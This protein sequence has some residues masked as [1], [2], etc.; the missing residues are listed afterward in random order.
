MP[1]TRKA[2]A[3]LEALS[4]MLVGPMSM[5]MIVSAPAPMVSVPILLFLLCATVVAPLDLLVDIVFLVVGIL[6]LSI[7]SSFRSATRSRRIVKVRRIA[8]IVGVLDLCVLSG[9][10]GACTTA[11]LD[12]LI[13]SVIVFVSG[14]GVLGLIG[15]V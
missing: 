11:S 3:P 15:H 2:I 9:L 7:R 6:V 13:K 14:T 12:L 1:A 4:M 10:S 5:M 8:S